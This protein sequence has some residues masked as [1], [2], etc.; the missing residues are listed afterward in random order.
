MPSYT[1]CQPREC[2]DLHSKAHLF[3]QQR[4]ILGES[5]WRGSLLLA[6]QGMTS[7]NGG[8]WCAGND[9][10]GT[11]LQRAPCFASVGY[12]SDVPPTI[13]RVRE[14][15]IGPLATIGEATSRSL[16]GC[17]NLLRCHTVRT[18]E[19][20]PRHA[21]LRHRPGAPLPR[22]SGE[23]VPNAG[24]NGC[25]FCSKTPKNPHVKPGFFHASYLRLPH[26]SSAYLD[27]P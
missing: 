27:T 2:A 7:V 5:V 10:P 8:L 16:R 14:V 15:D 4:R 21:P 23:I 11:P 9:S 24:A 6:Y 20:G 17:E 19:A 13:C 18:N 1:R 12:L 25:C 3:A 26:P 22:V